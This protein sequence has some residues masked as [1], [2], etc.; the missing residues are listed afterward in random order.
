MQVGRVY[1]VGLCNVSSLSKMRGYWKDRGRFCELKGTW[2]LEKCVKR[3]SST[4]QDIS[5]RGEK[6][7]DEYSCWCG[8][9]VLDCCVRKD[10]PGEFHCPRLTDETD[11][12][13]GNDN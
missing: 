2:M 1:V 5:Y 9:G 11:R 10:L 7:D 12:V 13:S 8:I 4:Y 6:S 3:R